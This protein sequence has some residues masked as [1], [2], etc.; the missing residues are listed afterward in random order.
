M[1]INHSLHLSE[2]HFTN[3]SYYYF[4]KKKQ[5]QAMHGK[6]KRGLELQ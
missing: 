6:V 4:C 5:K 2:M 3:F 1:T